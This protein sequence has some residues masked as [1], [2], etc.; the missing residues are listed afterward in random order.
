[1]LTNPAKLLR[2]PQSDQRIEEEECGVWEG[3]SSQN[4]KQWPSWYITTN[5]LL[6]QKLSSGY[7]LDTTA[8]R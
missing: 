8:K 1:V 5:H 4:S 7:L 6:S 3:A 2:I